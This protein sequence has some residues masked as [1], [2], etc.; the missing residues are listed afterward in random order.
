MLHPAF[1]ILASFLLGSIPFGFL[2]GRLKGIDIRQHGSKNIGATNVGR[3]LG[4]PLGFLCFGLDFLKGFLP[5]LGAGFALSS[6][7][8]FTVPTF[9]AWIWLGVAAAAIAGHMFPPWLR[10]KGG[11]GVATG[12][13]ALCGVWP[14]LGIPALLALCVWLLCVKV[15]RYVGV[16]S[17]LAALSLPLS[18]LALLPVASA[19]GVTVGTTALTPFSRG[20]ADSLASQGWPLWP[21]LVTVALLAAVVVLKHRGN[22]QRTLAGTE[23]RIGRPKP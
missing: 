17:C 19:L 10:F 4:R 18:V 6:I 11:K 9:E 15:S 22:I 3:T 8:R 21:F 13:G 16:S 12:F 20:G 14:V 23:S 2:I 5:A 1:L 7:G